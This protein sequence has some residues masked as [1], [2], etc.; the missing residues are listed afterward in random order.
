M[1]KP[2]PRVKKKKPKVRKPRKP[3]WLEPKTLET[4]VLRTLTRRVV[5][6]LANRGWELRG[7]P[8]E[9]LGCSISQLLEH[10]MKPHGGEW[11]HNMNIDHVVPISAGQNELEVRKLSHYSNLRLMLAVENCR[12]GSSITTDEQVALGLK[13]LGRVIEKTC[14]VFTPTVRVPREKPLEDK[15]FGAFLSLVCTLTK[16]IC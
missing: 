9:Y 11:L 14:Y 2:K 13:L 1:K 8:L 16:N 3:R 12:K 5:K 15:L 10:L 4:K 7:P 6:T